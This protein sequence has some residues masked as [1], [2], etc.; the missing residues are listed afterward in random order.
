MDEFKIVDEGLNRETVRL[1]ADGTYWIAP[2]ITE[3][4]ALRTLSELA[5]YAAMAHRRLRECDANHA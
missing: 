2:D 3:S 4:E 5:R 1:N